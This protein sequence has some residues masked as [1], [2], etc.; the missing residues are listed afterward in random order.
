MCDEDKRRKGR[1]EDKIIVFFSHIC[2]FQKTV[3]PQELTSS[4][5]LESER[6][7]ES[8]YCT[9]G[10]WKSD[11]AAT[12]TRPIVSAPNERREGNEGAITSIKVQFQNFKHSLQPISFL[13]YTHIYGTYILLKL[14]LKCLFTKILTTQRE[15]SI[16]C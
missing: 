4:W 10:S 12:S 2:I 6:V 14:Y 3:T 7:E 8:L 1:N 15:D 13:L 9:A 11:K 5:W 16:P